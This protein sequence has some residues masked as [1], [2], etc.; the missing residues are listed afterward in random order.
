MHVS[1]HVCAPELLGP[2]HSSCCPKSQAHRKCTVV[3]RWLHLI[4][5]AVGWGTLLPWGVAWDSRYGGIFGH[6]DAGL[7]QILKAEIENSEKW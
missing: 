6:V 2:Y 3:P 5:M 1:I 7:A 4:L